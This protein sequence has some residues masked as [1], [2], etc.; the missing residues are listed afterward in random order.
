ME[1]EKLEKQCKEFMDKHNLKI[2]VKNIYSHYGN[3][4]LESQEIYLVPK[5]FDSWKDKVDSVGIFIGSY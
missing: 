1:K 2:F 3:C 5:N 4:E